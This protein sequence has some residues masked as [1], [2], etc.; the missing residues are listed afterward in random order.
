MDRAKSSVDSPVA[1]HRDRSPSVP[2]RIVVALPVEARPFAEA[3]MLERRT[4][5]PYGLFEG[6]LPGRRHPVRLVISGVGRARCASAVGWLAAQDEGTAP[7]AVWLNVGVAGADRLADRSVTDETTPAEIGDVVVASSV[8]DASRERLLMAGNDPFRGV[9]APASAGRIPSW[10]PPWL[11]ERPAEELRGASDPN[12]RRAPVRT[13]DVPETAFE[14]VGA[15]EME[16]AAFMEAA[17]LHTSSELVH[18]VKIVSD[19]AR[20]GLAVVDRESVQSACAAAVPLVTRLLD[21]VSGWTHRS[22]DV[23]AVTDFTQSWS[24]RLR[25]SV[26]Q[27]HQFARL[28]ERAVAVGIGGLEG[29]SFEATLVDLEVLL[30]RLDG[31][32][33]QPRVRVHGRRVM[34]Q[35][36]AWVDEASLGMADWSPNES[37]SQPSVDR[38]GAEE[39]DAKAAA[40][41]GSST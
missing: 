5:G 1:T 7:R 13:V 8:V 35:F 33:D 17:L 26:A 14:A 25:F 29:E 31:D 27:R 3:W 23:G 21:E 34:Q 39:P 16:A 20:S 9:G 15:Y 30:R 2:I 38:A 11:G 10:Y 41:G 37:P 19:T 24:E 12:V 18:V 28:V 6:E 22:D 32:A 4:G 36:A 40:G